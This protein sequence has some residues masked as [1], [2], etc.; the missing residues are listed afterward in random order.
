MPIK[1]YAG[2]PEFDHQQEEIARRKLMAAL[3]KKF[4]ESPDAVFAVFSFYCCGQDIDL[5]FF[6]PNCVTVVEIKECNA[7]IVASEN[8]RW[9]IYNEDGTMAPLLGGGKNRNPYDQVRRASMLLRECMTENKYSY[10]ASQKAQTSDFFVKATIAISP[11]IHPKS[12]FNFDSRTSYWFSWCGLDALPDLLADLRNPRQNFSAQEL[13]KFIESVL[14]C[15]SLVDRPATKAGPARVEPSA[16]PAR[17]DIELASS[18]RSQDRPV[19]PSATKQESATPVYA[20]PPPALD[21]NNLCIFMQAEVQAKREKNRSDAAKPVKAHEEEGGVALGIVESVGTPGGSPGAEFPPILIALKETSRHSKMYPASRVDLY[22]AAG[23]DNIGA[24]GDLKQQMSRKKGTY[25]IQSVEDRMMLVTPSAYRPF[26]PSKGMTV[27]LVETDYGDDYM[28]RLMERM[29][30]VNERTS[31]I[32]NIA[33]RKTPD[34]V[35]HVPVDDKELLKRLEDLHKKMPRFVQGPPGTGKTHLIAWLALRRIASRK[36]QSVLVAA[37]TN[38][39]IDAI[40]GEISSLKKREPEFKTIRARKYSKSQF[41]RRRYDTA[42]ELLPEPNT[43]TLITLNALVFNNEKARAFPSILIDEA[44]QLTLIEMIF[45]ESLGTD[46]IFF[47][48][49]RQLG[50][51]VMHR[52]P[53]KRIADGL[54]HLYQKTNFLVLRQTWRLNPPVAERISS[55]FYDDLLKPHADLFTPQSDIPQGIHLVKSGPGYDQSYVERAEAEALVIR[56]IIERV[57]KSHPVE[58]GKTVKKGSNEQ[59]I[60]V[61]CLYRQQVTRIENALG[62]LRKGALVD[63]VERTQGRTATY[64]GVLSTAGRPIPDDPG[65]FAWIC[66]HRR[67]N[68]AISRS[69]VASVVV[70]DDFYLDQVASERNKDPLSRRAWEE[71]RGMQMPPGYLEL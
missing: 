63:S 21:K 57:R 68:V 67:L 28:I 30:T 43:I 46:V 50:P 9:I 17:P 5:A 20:E 10:L 55:W 56:R 33:N 26:I 59:D 42:Q 39:A 34:K 6:K 52:E 8:G 66:D 22:D 41:D 58:E 64:L 7:K 25:E 35:N 2:K 61:S 29:S 51:I 36:T 32:V 12:Q 31:S 60:I 14:H 47:G 11:T 1:Y 62:S 70:A 69:K 40:H 44:S 27:A 38:S 48:D 3:S 71:I 49:P 53:D 23:I 15:E 18:G 37:R 54:L 13:A 45:L 65:R 24:L 4:D 19:S 16:P